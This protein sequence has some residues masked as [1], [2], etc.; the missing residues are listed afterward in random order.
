[1]ENSA[2]KK[3][4]SSSVYAIQD[5]QCISSHREGGCLVPLYRMVVTTIQLFQARIDSHQMSFFP[6]TIREC[7]ELHDETVQAKTQESSEALVSI[8]LPKYTYIILS[9]FF[10]LSH[11]HILRLSSVL[12]FPKHSKIINLLKKAI[13]WQVQ[14]HPLKTT[15]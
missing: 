7:S 13:T 12:C 4:D 6:R 3:N 2:G 10:N 1:V 15:P 5:Q 8:T 9:S 14:I 11:I